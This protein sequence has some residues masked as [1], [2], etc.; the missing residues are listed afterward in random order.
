MRRVRIMAVVAAAAAL[1]LGAGTMRAQSLSL[2]DQQDRLRTATGDS[3]RAKARAAALERAAA[4]ERDEARK[5]RA[6]EAA[7]AARIQGAEADISAAQARIAIIER[8]LRVQR[9]RLAERQGPILR[10]VAALQSLSRRPAVLGLVQPGSTNDLVHVR[11]MLGTVLPVVEART[12]DVRA[13]L[14][15]VRRLRRGADRA[16]AGLRDGRSRLEG[17]RVA[18]VRLEAEH[19]LR[20]RELGRSAIVESDRAIALGEQARDI[21]DL[22]E[23]MGAAAE[24]REALDTLP[25]PLPRPLRPGEVR[26]VLETPR[27]ADKRLPP[28]RLPVSGQVVTGLGEVSSAGVRSRGLTLATVPGAQ[29]VA[30]TGGRVLYAGPFRG[31]GTIVILDHGG[32]WTSLV[33]GFDRVT[34]RVGDTV[35]QGGP[36][37]RAGAGEAPRVTVELRRRGRPIDLTPLLG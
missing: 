10:L 30:P 29:I 8:L 31:Y 24:T 32:G 19:R 25:G 20:S 26:A 36:L 21:V 14:E 5:A 28:Y 35:T 13:E 22:M 37:G 15:K 33:T 34:A 7:V 3:A 6:E 23:T 4:G 11:A 2:T 9:V 27:A 1:A 18:L 17:E 12:A 16:V